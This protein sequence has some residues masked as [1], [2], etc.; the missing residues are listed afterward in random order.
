MMIHTNELEKEASAGTHYLDCFRGTDLRRTEIACVVWMIQTL[1]GS[2]LQ[3]YSTQFYEQAG[4]STV[5]SFDFNMGQYAL[6]AIGTF[7]SWF[8]MTR[9]GRR[10]LYLWGLVAACIS[11]LIIGFVGIAPKSNTTAP[12]VIGSMLLIFT[13]IY[14]ATIG[15]VC[16]C[17]VA[18]ISS[19]R[20]KSKTIVLARN[21]YNVV[22][23][24]N[25]IITPRMINPTAWDWG[26]KAGFFWAV[27]CFLCIVWTYFRLP[28]PK[29]KTYAELDVLFERKLGARKFKN[30]QVDPFRADILKVRK[31][32]VAQV[33]SQQCED[34]KVVVTLNENAG[35][36]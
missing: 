4:I 31:D 18:E 28:E 2:G 26:A 32:G 21:F 19:T 17:L 10:T 22:G 13:F 3:G 20:L 29:G 30:A 35:R 34:E 11:L 1:C 6:G 5:F 9:M 27:S 25:N 16:Y 8:L 15:P 36:V 33:K 7:L 12:W 23:I 24:F 14:D